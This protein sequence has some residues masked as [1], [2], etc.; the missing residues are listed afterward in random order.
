MP[1]ISRLVV[2]IQSKGFSAFTTDA[3][4]AVD[5]MRLT[6]KESRKISA[7]V[8][9][10]DDAIHTLRSSMKTYDAQMLKTAQ[11]QDNLTS[12]LFSAIRDG[13]ADKTIQELANQYNNLDIEMQ[14]L[15]GN[16]QLVVIL[17][18]YE[19][20]SKRVTTETK[21]FGESLGT[22]KQRQDLARTAIMQMV[23]AGIDPASKQVQKL[24]NEYNSLGDQIK[25]TEK[26]T[27]DFIQKM[28]AF[29]TISRS[30]PGPLGTVAGALM[31]LVSP[32]MAVI[33]L[34]VRAVKATV[35]FVKQSVQAFGE[36]EL[37]KVILEQVLGSAELANSVFVEARE[38]AAKTPFSVPGV[39][40]AVAQLKQAGVATKDLITTVEMLGNVSGG[41]MERFSRIAYNYVQVL[42][43]R[44]FRYQ[45]PA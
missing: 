21:L 41:S 13:G 14:K 45:R 40:Q 4:K 23:N 7:A 34:S 27:N 15:Q 25:K 37:I 8:K 32:M 2:E 30:L 22:L 36:Y 16:K 6:E 44:R 3:E 24:R 11:A 38:L 33:D 35:D 10:Y 17:K 28:N 5:T 26:T 39:A 12:S 1:D 9:Q 42:Q 20:G 43:K 31:G 18:E 19:E 29:Q